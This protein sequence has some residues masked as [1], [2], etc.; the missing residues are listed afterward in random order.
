MIDLEGEHRAGHFQG[1]ATVV[2][3]LLTIVRPDR[4][5]FGQKDAQQCL[6]VKRLNE[7]LNLGSEIV[8]CPT[9]R[10]SDSLAL[11]SRN[12]YLD[13]TEREA[14]LSLHFAHSSLPKE[15]HQAGETDAAEIRSRMRRL[16]NEQPLATID[17]ISVADA[18]NLS[19][20]E[21][22]TGATLVFPR[23]PHRQDALDRQC[24]NMTDGWR[25]ADAIILD[26][27]A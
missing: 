21:I 26:L 18:E 20:L 7:D 11:S 9:V 5:Y 6:V 3:K 23:S 8:V 27:R 15:L 19:E 12:V 10:D 14:A 16:I 2:C 22:I 4:A 1:V 24:V 13:A 17:Y 25:Q